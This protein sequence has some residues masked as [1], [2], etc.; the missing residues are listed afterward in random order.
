MPMDKRQ[1][2]SQPKNPGKE[3]AIGLYAR[4]IPTRKI[5]GLTKEDSR[6]VKMSLDS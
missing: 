6:Q 2:N 1:E 5:A 4:K 3:I